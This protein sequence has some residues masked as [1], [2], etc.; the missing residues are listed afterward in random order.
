MTKYNAIRTTV[1]NITF[2]S[3]K[4]SVRYSELKMLLN[5]GKISMLELQ[6]K[7]D[8]IVN[9][10]KIGK[11]VADFEYYE[12]AGLKPEIFIRVIEDVKG[13][14]TPVYKLKKKH[15]EAQYGVVIREV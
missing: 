13:M 11:Y 4:E 1:D 7:F 14:K 12:P 8:L 6:P 10:K 5:A 15:V 3:K 2:A 9:G